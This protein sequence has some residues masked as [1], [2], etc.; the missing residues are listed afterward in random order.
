MEIQ[1]LGG[2][3]GIGGNF[4]KI[5]DGDHVLIFDQGIRFDV[6]DRFYSRSLRPQGVTELRDLGVLPKPEWY[7]NAQGIYITHL[8][9]DHLGALSNIPFEILVHL[10]NLELYE[11]MEARWQMS[12]SWLSLI[13]KKYYLKLA[14]M[15]TCEPDDN[16][17]VSIP[18]SHSAFP[19][20]SLLYYGE[21]ET[22][23]Y[24][25][26]FR[27]NSYLS[28]DEFWDLNGS[29]NLLSYLQEN[30]DIR[31]DTLITEGTNVGGSRSTYS[32]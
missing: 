15:K 1:I 28:D 32:R 10:P 5:T 16:N 14:E 25:G 31:I 4:I 29:K 13:P 19:A 3:K 17:V 18:V 6:M 27:T 21:K 11:T 9:L 2:S 30:T 8:H 24:T 23:L 12:P 20:R 22:V 26:D 7:E